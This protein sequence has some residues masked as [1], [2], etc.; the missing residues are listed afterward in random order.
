MDGVLWQ[1]VNVGFI[2]RWN[3]ITVQRSGLGNLMVAQ[4]KV[5]LNKWA[6]AQYAINLHLWD[7]SSPSGP[8]F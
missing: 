1:E 4:N 6:S 5:S 2:F 3:E 7:K 8:E